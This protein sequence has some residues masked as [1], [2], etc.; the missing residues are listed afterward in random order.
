MRIRRP[1][2][3]CGSRDLLSGQ[4]LLQSV[5]CAAK[6]FIAITHLAGWIFGD[7][8]LIWLA[9]ATLATRSL[10][11][12]SSQVA[13]ALRVNDLAL[14]R[15]RLSFIVSRD[16]SQL[17]EAAIV[18]ALVETVS[19]NICD[20]IVA[21]LFYLAL[22][23][24]VGALIYKAIN[25]MDSMLGYKNARYRYFGS[26]PARADDVA[27]FIPARISGWL[28]VGASAC[29]GKDWRSA[30]RIMRRDAPKMKSPNA[31]YPEA[32]TAGALGVQLGGTS[33]YFGQ[34][35]A[36]PLLGDPINPLTLEAY[37]RMI[38]LMYLSSGLAFLLAVCLMLTMQILG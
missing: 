2:L 18:R 33:V 31:G 34:P 16:T 13:S 37:R 20:A 22:F 1:P 9:Y 12:E 15:R 7:L 5:L 29:M 38:R 27:N 4:S 8:A 11:K 36:K 14:A 30:A 25:T 32:A 3:S 6:A 24:P 19:E 26:F 23:G 10:H 28:L 35:V 17:D 21:P